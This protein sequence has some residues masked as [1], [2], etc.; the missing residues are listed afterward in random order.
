MPATSGAF[1]ASVGGRW[2]ISPSPASRRAT[3]PARRRLG[4]DHPRRVIVAGLGL[5]A[6]FGGGLMLSGYVP[7]SL[8]L[9]SSMELGLRD[10]DEF[11]HTRV[12][13]VLFA[14]GQG[15][16]CRKV[17]FHNDSGMFGAD[18]KVRCDTGLPD[19]QTASVRP[20]GGSSGR[21]MSVRDA[22]LRR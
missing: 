1:K 6:I 11:G 16:D 17:K 21:L 2:A 3:P 14:T 8:S 10:A 13:D 22:F 7:F 5:I 4:L 12:G 19:D 20:G 18:M 9:R 15:N